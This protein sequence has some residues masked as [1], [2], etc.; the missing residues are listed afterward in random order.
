MPISVVVPAYN[1]EDVIG[2]C[3]KDLLG[4]GDVIGE[5]VVVD[6]ASTD[7]TAQIVTQISTDHPKVVI[8]RE[9]RPGVLPARN[10]GFDSA[11]LDVV[12]RIDAD[13]L[14][15]PGWAQAV[16]DFFTNTGEE[17]GAVVGPFYQHDMPFRRLS[18]AMQRAIVRFSSDGGQTETYRVIKNIAGGNMAIRRNAWSAVRDLVTTRN[19]VYED[20][21]L[22]LALTEAGQ[23]MAIVH[24]MKA[25]VSG[26]RMKTGFRSYWRYTAHLPATFAARGLHSQARLSWVS[27]WIARLFYIVFYVPNRA[28]DPHTRKWNLKL[29]L[30]GTEER[31]GPNR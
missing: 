23:K 30:S 20:V 21:D 6:N 10:T 28:F 8:V 26:R 9:E 27:V 13:T 3:L 29:L 17:F 7:R 31:V 5:I 15:E 19:D 25:S 12:A 4:Q 14:V 1:E 16:E 24:E 22:S 2:R 11:T 18:E